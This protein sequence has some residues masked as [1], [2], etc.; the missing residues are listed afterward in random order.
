MKEILYGTHN[1]LTTYI[2]LKWT[3]WENEI[4]N[5]RDKIHLNLYV[6]NLNEI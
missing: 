6:A 3:N 4:Y 5:P 1:W 2:H